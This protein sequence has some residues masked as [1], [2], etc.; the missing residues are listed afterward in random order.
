ML[1]LRIGIRDHMPHP[2]HYLEV[3]QTMLFK[4]FRESRPRF[5]ISQRAF[6]SLKPFYCVPLKI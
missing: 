4:Q 1:K 6:E 3:S 2:K 5:H